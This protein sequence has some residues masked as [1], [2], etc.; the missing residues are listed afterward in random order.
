MGNLPN[1]TITAQTITDIYAGLH[2]IG[3]IDS[4]Y[5]RPA[6]S[7]VETAAI[8]YIQGLADQAGLSHYWDAAAN[9]IIELQ[10]QEDRWVES[11]SHLDTVP[12]GGNYDGAAGVIAALSVL[13]YVKKSQLRPYKGLRLRVWRGEESASFGV[14]S[15]GARAIM[16]VLPNEAWEQMHNGQSLYAAMQAQGADA[17][18]L[19]TGMQGMTSA[20]QAVISAYV[21]LH[22]EQGNVLEQSKKTIGVVTG[23]RGSIRS[24]VRLKGRFDHSGATPMGTEFRADVNLAMSYM[25]VRLHELAQEYGGQDLVQT[26][27][28]VNLNT[29]VAQALPDLRFNAVSKVSGCGFFSHEIRSC[30]LTLMDAYMLRVK[31]IVATTA[32]EFGV[33]MALE[34]FSRMVGI[35]ALDPLIQRTIADQCMALNIPSI[36]LPSGAWHDAGVMAQT[37]CRDGR[38]IPVGMIFI[39]SHDGVSHSPQEWTSA[40]DIATGATVLLHTM[41]QLAAD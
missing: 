29:S 20:Q 7:D 39:P 34:T 5:D 30:S 13:I 19:R 10:G 12:G 21:E 31:A 22:I 25:Q 3:Q 15:I 23:I 27:G 11:G 32:A 28:V 6:Y 8:R 41:L 14:V 1:Q 26:I 40:A 38:L 17:K 36:P 2:A 4:G 16:G 9:L 35:P 18:A 24:W 37:E 33:E